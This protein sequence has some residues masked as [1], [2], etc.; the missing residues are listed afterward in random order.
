[1]EK[2]ENS[3]KNND[4]PITLI[5][6]NLKLII[7]KLIFLFGLIIAG[8]QFSQF[9]SSLMNAINTDFYLQNKTLLNNLALLVFF[10]IMIQLLVDLISFGKVTFKK[11]IIHNFT[12]EIFKISKFLTSSRIKIT[13]FLLGFIFIPLEWRFMFK[14]VDIN[15][16][17]LAES[18]YQQYS[19]L[20]NNVF[21][22]FVL[23]YITFMIYLS[24]KQVIYEN[25]VFI[26]NK[27]NQI[28]NKLLFYLKLENLL[29]KENWEEELNKLIVEPAYRNLVRIYKVKIETI[30]P[31][32]E[33]KFSTIYYNIY[34]ETTSGVPLDMIQVK[35]N[36]YEPISNFYKSLDNITK[37][38]N[39]N[40]DNE[41][42]KEDSNSESEI[43]SDKST[44]SSIKKE[45]KSRPLKEK[46]SNLDLDPKKISEEIKKRIENNGNN[47]KK[48]KKLA[49][50]KNNKKRPGLG[51]VNPRL[52]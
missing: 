47:L 50:S 12:R 21:I 19:N 25:D 46:E 41:L 26:L 52:K 34:S 5:G 2:L 29:Q 51:K 38:E 18:L 32:K 28:E 23:L 11:K 37:N 36:F 48:I 39:Q 27:E 9:L 10:I 13:S 4:N 30:M 15:K 14:P 17:P 43:N 6:L 7:R 1:M 33:N 20:S 24:R 44:L 22:F 16:S 40:K 3:M 42:V 31:S 45:L 35:I 8:L 49:P